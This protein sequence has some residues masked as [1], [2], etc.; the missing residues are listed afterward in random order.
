MNTA[1]FLKVLTI[2]TTSLAA[3]AAGLGTLPIDSASLPMPPSWRPYLMG[4]AFSRQPSALSSCQCWRMSLSLSR[5]KNNTMKT[6]AHLLAAFGITY[7]LTSC[8]AGTP[9]TVSA[10]YRTSDGSKSG[11]STTFVPVKKIHPDK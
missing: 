7:V 6:L 1:K 9:L 2:V 10:F 4:V 5:T 3:L 11:L 8:E